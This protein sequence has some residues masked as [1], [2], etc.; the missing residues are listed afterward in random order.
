MTQSKTLLESDNKSLFINNEWLK[1]VGESF[2]SMSPIDGNIIWHGQHAQKDEVHEAVQS[3]RKALSTWSNLPFANRCQVIKKFSEIISYKKDELSEL[4]SLETGKPLWESA[5]EVSAVV[6]KVNISINAYRDRTSEKKLEVGDAKG[7]LRFKPHGVVAVLG[8][9]NFPAHLS[10]GHIV[11]ALLAGNTVVL[12]PSELTPAVSEFIIKCWEIAGLP[13]GVINCIQGDARTAKHLIEE[14]IQGVYFTGSYQA[15][16]SISKQLSDRPEVILALEMGGNNP[17]VID[18]VKDIKAAVYHAMVS[19]FVTAGQRCTCARRIFIKNDAQGDQ[20]LKSFKE[21]SKSLIIGPYNQQPEPFYGTVISHKHAISHL[22]SQQ[23]LLDAGA[24]PILK[25][26]LIHENSGFLSPGIVSM[27]NVS[28]VFD[29]EIFAPF[30]QIYRYSD[31]DDAIEQANQTKYGLAAG[32]LTE[33]DKTYQHFY[34]SI[35][36]GIIN[37]NRP[38]TGAASSLPFGGVGHSGNHRPSAWFAADYC[39]FP[40]SSIEQNA[41]ALPES[42]MPGV[43]LS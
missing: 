36:A 6:G 21:A 8:P 42:L 32:I 17:L 9:F 14:D 40:V 19:S 33:N 28:E 27:S 2:Y 7:H 35:R 26:S 16:L 4:I 3:A 22:K 20:L 10:N 15:G 39:A 41:L 5:T 13:S 1:G 18:N 25:M 38:T 29:E 24:E 12:K 30:V 31:L 11:P 23:K 34:N 37:W 43:R